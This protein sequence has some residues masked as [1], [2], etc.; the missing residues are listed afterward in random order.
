MAGLSGLLDCAATLGPT[1]QPREGATL[2]VSTPRH[3][4]SCFGPRQLNPLL[5]SVLPILSKLQRWGKRHAVLYGGMAS[6]LGDL[7][8]SAC[9]LPPCTPR[10][11]PRPHRAACH[12]YHLRTRLNPFPPNALAPR[13]AH[14]PHTAQD[15]WLLGPSLS[16]APQHHG[17]PRL[18]RS[19]LID[20]DNDMGAEA[21]SSDTDLMWS[22]MEH[23]KVTSPAPRSGA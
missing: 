1:P 20:N 8:V 12:R 23:C 13:H 9:A 11:L 18:Q 14:T 10:T 7:N 4:S 2:T 3:R 19:S 15:V 21:I 5:C 17:P 16:D 6:D 22:E